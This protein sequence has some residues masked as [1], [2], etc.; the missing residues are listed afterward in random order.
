MQGEE[1]NVRPDPCI[2]DSRAVTPSEQGAA[3]FNV[4]GN[5]SF[6]FAGQSDEAWVYR[7]TRTAAVSRGRITNNDHLITNSSSESSEIVAANILGGVSYERSVCL[8]RRIIA[9]NSYHGS[10]LPSG[11]IRRRDRIFFRKNPSTTSRHFLCARF[12]A[13]SRKMMARV[14]MTSDGAFPPRRIRTEVV[15]FAFPTYQLMRPF[16]L[17]L[18]RYLR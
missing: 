16:L 3:A 6:D 10:M 9:Q 14:P 12:P 5:P 4:L 8:G 17:A 15:A 2:Q 7:R 1:N 13:L 18:C 11:L